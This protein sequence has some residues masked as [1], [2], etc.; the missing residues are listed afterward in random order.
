M[1][2]HKRKAGVERDRNG[3]YDLIMRVREESLDALERAY[4]LACHGAKEPN[5][6]W[7]RYN[8][9]WYWELDSIYHS[10]PFLGGHRFNGVVICI[11]GGS[12]VAKESVIFERED[13]YKVLLTTH[14]IRP[15]VQPVRPAAPSDSVSQN[16][17]G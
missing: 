14:P 4:Q 2:R 17:A 16:T 3:K 12:R 11:T 10:A 15:R 9:K 1:P 8:S 5:K 6:L 7:V 13:G